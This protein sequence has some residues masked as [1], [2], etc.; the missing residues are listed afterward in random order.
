MGVEPIPLAYEANEIPFLYP[1][2]VPD[3]PGCGLYFT[4]HPVHGSLALSQRR[5]TQISSTC[6]D[7]YIVSG[8]A[9][10]RG[11]EPRHVGLESTALPLSYKTWRP[12]IITHGD[13]GIVR[14]LGIE[15]RTCEV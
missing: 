9:E 1:Q 10:L 4:T 13:N 7:I 12:V 3:Y 6:A 8:F 14:N 2:V 15:P 11:I 5:E